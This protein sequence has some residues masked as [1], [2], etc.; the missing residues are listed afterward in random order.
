VRLPRDHY[1]RLDSNDYSVHPAAVGRMVEVRAD[2]QHVTVSLA[3]CDGGQDSGRELARHERCWAKHQ[4]LTDPEHQQPAAK[5]RADRQRPR[6]DDPGVEAVE[7]RE[8][9]DYDAAFGLLDTGRV[10]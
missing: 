7:R 6:R 8:L 4:S 2:L 10:A 9:T 3:G 5:M 1:V